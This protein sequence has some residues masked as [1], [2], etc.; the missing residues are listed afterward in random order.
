MMS[1]S[2]YEA[3]TSA[4]S[5]FL[6]SSFETSATGL[7][8]AAAAFGSTLAL[9]STFLASSFLGAAAYVE[10]GLS[11]ASSGLSS[12]RPCLA[13]A[14]SFFSSILKFAA[15]KSFGNLSKP[16]GMLEIFY[17]DI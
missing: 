5:S 13:E 2:F 11:P 6:S 7:P 3:T 15:F 9:G 14:L 1:S 10:A 17:A 4:S 16:F 8:L 12:E